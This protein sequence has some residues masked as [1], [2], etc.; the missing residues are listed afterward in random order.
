MEAGHFDWQH[1]VQCGKRVGY[2][3][4]VV[5]NQ[6]EYIREYVIWQE[7]GYFKGYFFTIACQDMDSVD[8]YSDH[9]ILTEQHILQNV[10]VFLQAYGLEIAKLNVFKGSQLI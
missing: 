6:L 3:E 7:N 10:L 1:A 8:D 9:E 5:I 4:S 2:S